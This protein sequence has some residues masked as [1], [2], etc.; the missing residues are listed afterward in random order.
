M[1]RAAVVALFL[2]YASGSV[3]IQQLWSGP[4]RE[5]AAPAAALTREGAG[6]RRPDLGAVR[7]G[8]RWRAVVAAGRSGP[9]VQ[10][11]TRHR[12][13]QKHSLC[14]C[15][16]SGAMLRQ[17]RRL[18]ARYVG[19]SHSPQRY[20]YTSASCGSLPYKRTRG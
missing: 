20:S 4:Q 3:R 11:T 12:R 2:S 14:L 15:E 10:V 5:R 8:D 17:A 9:A 18:P 16:C 19:E 6:R 7:H 1:G 13:T